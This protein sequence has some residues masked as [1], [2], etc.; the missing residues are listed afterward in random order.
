[1]PRLWITSGQARDSH[2]LFLR[3]FGDVDALIICRGADELYAGGP[4]LS[5]DPLTLHVPPASATAWALE[6]EWLADKASGVEARS[7]RFADSG[8]AA[9]CTLFAASLVNGSIV[10]DVSSPM[11]MPLDAAGI[12]LADRAALRASPQVSQAISDAARRLGA[13]QREL[14]LM[15][16]PETGG[17]EP[18]LLPAIDLTPDE[19]AAFEVRIRRDRRD[20]LKPGDWPMTGAQDWIEIE[21]SREAADA[22]ASGLLITQVDRQAARPHYAIPGALP[23]IETFLPYRTAHLVDLALPDRPEIHDGRAVWTIRNFRAAR[24]DL[25]VI[26]KSGQD[27]ILARLTG[28]DGAEFDRSE[29]AGSG[30]HYRGAAN[31]IAVFRHHGAE[32][33][34]IR[35]FL[36]SDLNATEDYTFSEMPNIAPASGGPSILRGLMRGGGWPGEDIR[37]FLALAETA[38]SS[39]FVEALMARRW[40]N[41]RQIASGEDI[42]EVLGTARV[43]QRIFSAAMALLGKLETSRLSRTL[44]AAALGQGV[45]AEIADADAAGLAA[46]ASADVMT[47]GVLVALI[48][49]GY[50]AALALACLRQKI[51]PDLADLRV[52]PT[53]ERVLQAFGENVDNLALSNFVRKG[54]ALHLA[55]ALDG[56][57][58]QK[59]QGRTALFDQSVADRPWLSLSIFRS[60]MEPTTVTR[61]INHLRMIEAALKDGKV[62]PADVDVAQGYADISNAGGS[63]PATAALL[64]QLQ[65]AA[66]A[67]DGQAGRQGSANDTFNR[68]LDDPLVD[69]PALWMGL[70][71]L[72]ELVAKREALRAMAAGSDRLAETTPAMIRL[73]ESGL[74]GGPDWKPAETYG[75][76]PQAADTVSLDA[77]AHALD[78]ALMLAGRNRED[79]DLYTVAQARVSGLPADRPNRDRIGA[80]LA[81]EWVAKDMEAVL[82]GLADECKD[83]LATTSPFDNEIYTIREALA[84][85]ASLRARNRKESLIDANGLQ[86]LIGISQIIDDLTEGARP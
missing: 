11:A 6:A 45:F 14:L 51:A 77:D 47:R 36:A 42:A 62:P 17:T 1:M 26:R 33:E 4:V 37:A 65:G 28:P 73:V 84:A 25:F 34:L 49:T 19:R 71:A 40:Q 67:F 55:L 66:A 12:P 10:F 23:A 32:I 50:P 78:R 29:L 57:D 59:A 30:S 27:A 61:V 39:G 74:S 22:V 82:Q 83:Q 15:L 31:A 75:P 53:L 85:I 70:Q 60:G 16:S 35:D 79:L 69:A 43:P 21:T 76:V 46:A 44:D 38:N 81:Y 54:L 9:N 72:Q 86:T 63:A 58:D 13:G 5:A 80:C 20:E 56:T 18:E 48:L 3:E 64:P 68:V 2:V 24:G 52:L 41:L 7:Y 8:I